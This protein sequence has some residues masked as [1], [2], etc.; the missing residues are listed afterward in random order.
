MSTDNIGRGTRLAYGIGSIAYGIKN[1]GFSTFL[2]LYFNQVLGLPAILVGLSL[3][4]ALMFDAISD[5]L[6]GYISDRHKSRLGRRHPFMYAA[7]LP[8][9]IAYFYMWTPPDLGQTGLFVYLTVMAILAQDF[10][11]P[12]H[13]ALAIDLPFPATVM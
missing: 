8:T 3:L 7:I 13:V 9:C 6:V 2:M 5:P 12:E 4:I 10:P 1:N 11:D